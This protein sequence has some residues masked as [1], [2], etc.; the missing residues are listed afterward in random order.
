MVKTTL[1][2]GNLSLKTISNLQFPVS[3]NSPKLSSYYLRLWKKL[4]LINSKLA[5]PFAQ[6]NF[7]TAYKL[8][9]I[10]V[11][12]QLTVGLNFNLKP[13]KSCN[14]SFQPKSLK[15]K[16]V[17]PENVKFKKDGFK[18]LRLSEE[19]YQF[20]SLKSQTKYNEMA[21]KK[22]KIIIKSK[23]DYIIEKFSKYL[24]KLDMK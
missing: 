17:S 2:S 3:S 9:L 6:L 20:I 15:F 12:Q 11:Q 5:L 23:A 10:K 21:P 4:Y 1:K 14:N 22:R 13:L 24:D 8:E 7:I 18:L 19:Q 16:K